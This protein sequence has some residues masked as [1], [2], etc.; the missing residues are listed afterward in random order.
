MVASL[1]AFFRALNSSH[2]SFFFLEVL[3]FFLVMDDGFFPVT[4]KVRPASAEV[5]GRSLAVAVCAAVGVG[6][7]REGK[8]FLTCAFL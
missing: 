5:E 7:G 8:S 4:V 2:L 1:A 3:I 6:G